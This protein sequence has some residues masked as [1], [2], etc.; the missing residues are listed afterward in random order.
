ML[1]TFLNVLLLV[2]FLLSGLAKLAD[3]NNFNRTIDQLEVDKRLVQPL[4]SAV[5]VFELAATIL[6]LFPQT[7]F[8]AYLLVLFLLGGF[9]WSIY[10]AYTRQLKVACNCFGNINAESFGWN[11]AL[12]VVLLLAVTLYLISM[13]TSVDWT[14][15]SIEDLVYAVVGSV[16]LLLVYNLLPYALL[17]LTGAKDS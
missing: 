6:L 4:A 9:S 5:V 3:F 8:Y 7:Q 17:G 10:R 14:T 15:Y 16:G 11:T 12:R 2:I 1:A 13:G